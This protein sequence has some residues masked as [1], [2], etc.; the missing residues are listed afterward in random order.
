MT[1]LSFGEELI[2]GDSSDI[3]IV[4]SPTLPAI[5]IYKVF[6]YDTSGDKIAEFDH[7]RKL[8]F[9]HKEN[10]L[11]VCTFELNGSDSRISL[12]G[13]DTQIHV[14]RYNPNANLDYYTEWKGF[15]VDIDPDAT[16]KEGT[17]TFTSK[18]VSF[19]DLLKRRYVLYDSGSIYSDKSDKGETVIKEYVGENAGPSATSP[20]WSNGVTSGLTIE[21]DLAT[22]LDWDG[23]KSNQPLLTTIQGVA[24]QSELVFRVVQLTTTTWE[25]RTYENFSGTDRS[26]V[27]LVPATGLNGAGESPI[28]FQLENDNIEKISYSLKRSNEKNVIVATGGGVGDEQLFHVETLPTTTSSPW[29]K[30][31]IVVRG[32][33]DDLTDDLETVAIDFAETNK[34]IDKITCTI[35]QNQAYVYGRDYFFGDKVT[36]RYNDIVKNAVITGVN[37]ILSQDGKETIKFTFD[38]MQ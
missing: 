34:Q 9:S 11:G 10:S 15:H 27:G 38:R 30:R 3:I 6:L 13:P 25:F 5:S 21:S 14:L 22:G 33:S 35:K 2:F 8:T 26:V 28:V 36:I 37:I 23:K 31:E 19:E 1:D 32:K 24:K 12:F 20:R 16:D 17:R 7:W 29:N 18:C 4:S